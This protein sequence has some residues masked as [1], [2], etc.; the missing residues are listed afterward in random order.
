MLQHFI[1]RGKLYVCV[2]DTHL[3]EHQS[4]SK[5]KS[6]A[7]RASQRVMEQRKS[8]ANKNTCDVCSRALGHNFHVMWKG[9]WADSTSFTAAS[10]LGINSARAVQVNVIAF[11]I[12]HDMKQ[13]NFCRSLLEQKNPLFCQI[14]RVLIKILSPIFRTY[15]TEC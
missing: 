4:R 9:F 7:L 10:E 11:S 12:L 6:T 5:E 15:S 2:A 13:V 14:D 3:N 1:T 8:L